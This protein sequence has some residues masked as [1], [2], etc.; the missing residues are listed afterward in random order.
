MRKK[1]SLLIKVS[2]VFLFGCASCFDADDAHLPQMGYSIHSDEIY[3]DGEP[4]F[5]YGVN[6]MQTYG[7]NNASLMR[8][9]RIQKHFITQEVFVSFDETNSFHGGCKEV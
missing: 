7:L 3:F 9:W 4:V 2:A 5:Y 6:A 1:H 8:D